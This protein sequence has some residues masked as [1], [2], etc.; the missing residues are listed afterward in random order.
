MFKMNWKVRLRNPVFW[1]T[2]L[3]ALLA[4]VYTLLGL[5]GVVPSVS[6]N[7]A[8]KAVSVLVSALTS[9]GVLVDPTTSGVS[10]SSRALTYDKPYKSDSEGEYTDADE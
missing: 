6:E 2:G 1:L 10:D 8:V 7:A 3:S 4:F 9:L 5:F